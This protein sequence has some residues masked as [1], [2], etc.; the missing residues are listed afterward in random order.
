VSIL[1]VEMSEKNLDNFKNRNTKNSGVQL[2]S[3]KPTQEREKE[4]V[5]HTESKAVENVQSFFTPY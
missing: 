3:E 2:E 1:N 5:D 4:T